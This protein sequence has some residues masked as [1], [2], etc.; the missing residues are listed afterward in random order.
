[1][2]LLI[3]F[4]A[5]F[6]HAI[7]S[8]ET[9]RAIEWYACSDKKKYKIMS[10]KDRL[11][12]KCQSKSYNQADSLIPNDPQ[13]EVTGMNLVDLA[14]FQLKQVQLPTPSIS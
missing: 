8:A 12:K 10:N 2:N 3:T 1:M 4:S 7:V 14:L 5:S 9:Q 6:G 13:K 11:I